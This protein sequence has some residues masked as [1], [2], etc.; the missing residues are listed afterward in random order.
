[1]LKSRILLLVGSAVIV[2][3]AM[4]YSNRAQ[5][6]VEGYRFYCSGSTGVWWGGSN[7]Y[8]YVHNYRRCMIP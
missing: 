6:Q 4:S 5:A 1:M 8:M 7:N 2:L 3:A